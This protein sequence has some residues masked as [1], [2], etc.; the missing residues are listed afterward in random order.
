[1]RVTFQNGTVHER[2]G[3]TFVRIADDILFVTG[4]VLLELPLDTGGESRAAASAQTGS[5]DL[6]NN[7]LRG[8]GLQD[9]IQS[10]IAADTDILMNVLRVDLTAVTKGDPVLFFIEADLFNVID[11]GTGILVDVIHLHVTDD[12]AADHV[13]IDDPLRVLR[14]HMR[15]ENTVRENSDDR[16][17]LTETEAAGLDDTDLILQLMLFEQLVQTLDQSG[18]FTRGTAGTGTA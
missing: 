2:A 1:M 16:S 10:L 17:L 13:L 7:I 6:I 8:H 14:L 18:G 12:I 15:I 4:L 9:L 5:L 3:V 11:L